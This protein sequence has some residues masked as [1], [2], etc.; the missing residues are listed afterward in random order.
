MNCESIEYYSISHDLIL[1]YTEMAYNCFTRQHFS[2]S[3]IILHILPH[4]KKK[5]IFFKYKLH[6]VCVI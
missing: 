3:Y 6:L 1:N 4:R 5:R 2:L